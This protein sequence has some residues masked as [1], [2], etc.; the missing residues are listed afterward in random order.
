DNGLEVFQRGDLA[1]GVA[2][3][4]QR[5]VFLSDTDAVVAH[6]D[7]LDAAVFELNVDAVGAGVEAV[8]EQFLDHG[9]RTFDDFTGGNLV[10]QPL[11]EEVDAGGV[12]LGHYVVGILSTCPTRI[13]S[14]LSWLALRISSRGTE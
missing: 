9:S 1:R 11:A 2:A 13:V 7:Q 14:L 6:A 3:Q 10:A 4:R 12:G 8:L 5:Q